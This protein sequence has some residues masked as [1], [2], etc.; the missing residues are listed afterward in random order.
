MLSFRLGIDIETAGEAVPALTRRDG[1]KGVWADSWPP[2]GTSVSAGGQFLL[3]A[4]GHFHVRQWA[5]FHVRRHTHRNGANIIGE[6][7]RIR[8]QSSGSCDNNGGDFIVWH[9]IGESNVTRVRTAHLCDDL[10]MIPG[11]GNQIGIGAPTEK[12]SDLLAGY[13]SHRQIVIPVSL[14]TASAF[15]GFAS[16]RHTTRIA[17]WS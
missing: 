2:T 4:D 5:V 15:S 6:L 16:Y 7:L 3:A 11:E 17:I 13:G 10:R 8:N 14:I 9:A 12:I 1:I